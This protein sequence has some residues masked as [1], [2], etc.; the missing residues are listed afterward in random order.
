MRVL[1][2]GGSGF[3]GL[4]TARALLDEGHDVVCTRFRTVRQPSFLEGFGDRL[5]FEPCDIG[6]E[7]AV[8]ELVGRSGIDGIIH[9]AV[10]GLGALTPSEETRSNVLGL[11][12]V[13]EAARAHGV[14]RTVIGSSVAVYFGLPSGPFEEHMPLP[15]PST[16]N[17]TAFK[18]TIEILTL[19]NAPKMGIDVVCARLGAIYGPLYHSMAKWLDRLLHTA[20]RSENLLRPGETFADDHVDY[21]YVKDCARGLMLLQTT[22]EL[23]ERIYNVG[24]GRATSNAMVATAVGAVATLPERVLEP[25]RRDSAADANAYMSLERMTRDTGYVPQYDI[26][27][28]MRDYAAWLKDNPF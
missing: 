20:L 28:A 17:T 16:T 4:H 3:I 19:Q 24:S 10:P 9:L 13:L 18:K 14:Q 2:T 25:G 1:I 8:G 27:A 6:D 26:V 12:N 5:R 15:I 23:P 22:A 7:A 11:L 21:C